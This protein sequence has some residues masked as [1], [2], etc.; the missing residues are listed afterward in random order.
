MKVKSTQN[1]LESFL[2]ADAEK[3]GVAELWVEHDGDAEDKAEGGQGRN[4]QFPH[5]CSKNNQL[6][7]FTPHFLHFGNW[8]KELKVTTFFSP[9]WFCTKTAWQTMM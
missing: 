3:V 6:I 5:L 2:P 4:Q 1:L 8:D 7:I 9:P